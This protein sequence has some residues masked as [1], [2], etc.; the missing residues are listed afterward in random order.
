MNSQSTAVWRT[1]REVPG[2]GPKTLAKVVRTLAEHSMSVETLINATEGELRFLGLNGVLTQKVSLALLNLSEFSSVPSDLSVLTPDS[3]FYPTMKSTD[4][5]PLPVVLYTRGN[6][7]L[8]LERAAGI[9][10]TRS[11]SSKVL[12]YVVRLSKH[13]VKE[14][15]VV[16]SGHAAGT[17]EQAHA[18]TVTAGGRT[19]AVLAEGFSRFHLRPSLRQ[20]DPDCLLLVSGFD[21]EDSWSVYRAMQRNVSIAALS[22][23]VIVVAASERGGS[24]GQGELCLRTGKKLLV[25]DFPVTVAAGNRK[26]IEMGGVAI[27]SETP[28]SIFDDVPLVPDSMERIQ[29]ELT[30]DS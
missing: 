25:P 19:I 28:E 4:S 10:G 3:P 6:Q 21:P 12:E 11:P 30:L 7:S 1:L 13:L 23:F 8:L 18:S 5:L 24:F 26:L 20:V 27:D 15:F 2:L 29:G 9:S 17:D 14:G 22:E 16:V